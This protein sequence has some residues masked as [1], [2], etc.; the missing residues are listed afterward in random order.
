MLPL[1]NASLHQA[2]LYARRRPPAR[3][4]V[5]PLDEARSSS[6]SWEAR[7]KAQRIVTSSSSVRV[8]AAVPPKSGC[9]RYWKAC[10]HVSQ[11]R[12]MSLKG[13]LHERHLSRRTFL[14]HR[15]EDQGKGAT[16]A[17][18][19]DDVHH[20][21]WVRPSDLVH[22]RGGSGGRTVFLRDEVRPEEPEFAR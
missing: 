19:L 2:P 8:G 22:V 10:G 12:C 3:S 11:P 15:R 16:L 14:I 6:L 7:A 21:G 9:L 17:H 1:T 18:P 4:A 13:V 5:V 20:C